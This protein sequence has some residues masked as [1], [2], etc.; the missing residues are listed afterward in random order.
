[1]KHE[2][3]LVKRVPASRANVIANY[4]DLE[5]LPVHSGLAGC[6]V[7]SE[8]DR[9][10]CFEMTSWVGPLRFRNVHYFEFRPPSDIFHAVKSPLGPMYVHSSVAELGSGTPGVRCE[11][12][13]RTVVDIPAFLYP[14]RGLVERILRRLNAT[15]LS[16]DLT[17]LERRAAL[18]GDNVEDYLRDQQVILFKETFRRHY[19]RPRSPAEPAGPA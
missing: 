16:E 18:F 6:R 7:M 11:V 5:H 8:T 2:F 15:V 12:T 17:I 3:T 14:V 19:S 10:A 4:L 9:A 13:V 1:M